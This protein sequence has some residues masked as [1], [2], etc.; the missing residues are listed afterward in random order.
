MSAPAPTPSVQELRALFGPVLLRA[1]IYLAFGLTTVFWQEPTLTVV[2]WGIGLFMI[3]QGVAL[4]YMQRSLTE[5]AW[6]H[7]NTHLSLIHI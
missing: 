5:R 2:R 6:G 4:I 1:V 7:G 3:L